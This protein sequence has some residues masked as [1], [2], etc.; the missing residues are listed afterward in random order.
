MVEMVKSQEHS[1]QPVSATA[2]GIDGS[3]VSKVYLGCISLYCLF[4]LFSMPPGCMRVPT[5]WVAG[6]RVACIE[7]EH[8]HP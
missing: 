6:G 2:R 7:I 8:Y 5:S 1:E 4:R 3:L